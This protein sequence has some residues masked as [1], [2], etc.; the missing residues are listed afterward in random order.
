MLWRAV[1]HAL[2]APDVALRGISRHRGQAPSVK[3]LRDFARHWLLGIN[4]LVAIRPAARCM[5]ITNEDAIRAVKAIQ[6]E[7]GDALIRR[8]AQSLAHLLRWRAP[9]ESELL[10]A[11]ALLEAVSTRSDIFSIAQ[12]LDMLGAHQDG[13][14]QALHSSRTHCHQGVPSVPDF[15]AI[16]AS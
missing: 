9:G 14:E 11:E 6:P 3:A 16:P 8:A 5:A 2:G 1:L 4:Q 7:D 13:Q 10:K 15:Q 12:M